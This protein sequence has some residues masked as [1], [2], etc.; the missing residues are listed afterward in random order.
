ML[1][2]SHE[3][4]ISCTDWLLLDDVLQMDRQCVQMHGFLSTIFI[5]GV[6]TAQGRSFS[7]HVFNGYAHGL[8]VEIERSMPGGTKA[9]LPPFASAALLQAAAISPPQDM[10]APPSPMQ[11]FLHQLEAVK[12]AVA[13]E[14]APWPLAAH[15]AARL[16]AQMPRQADRAAFIE[17]LG[18][19][20]IVACQYVDDTTAPCA[21]PGAVAAVVRRDADSA[22]T[23]FAMKTKSAFNYKPN[24]TAVMAILGSP[25][26]DSEELSCDVVSQY[27]LLGCLM[28]DMLTS[29]PLLKETLVKS[30]ALF[31]EVFHAAETGGFSVPVLAAQVPARV[32]PAILFVA[33]LLIMAPRM[34]G[35]LNRLQASW[36]RDILGCRHA[37]EIRWMLLVAQCGWEMRLSS[38][39]W[40]SA[41]MAL[42]RLQTLPLMHPGARMLNLAGASTVPCWATIVWQAM[43][44]PE[45]PAPIPAITECPEFTAE[46]MEAVHT[47]RDLRRSVL[48]RYRDGV[49]KPV[50]AALDKKQLIVA[51]MGAMVFPGISFS[52]LQPVLEKPSFDLLDLDM[53]PN[54]WRAYRCWAILRMTG[55]WPATCFGQRDLPL[56]LHSCPLCGQRDILPS[57]CLCE[58]Q[59]TLALLAG[60]PLRPPSCEEPAFLSML[61]GSAGVPP[62][63]TRIKYVGACV[64]AMLA[65]RQ[66]AMEPL[67]EWESACWD[68][69]G[70][71]S[72]DSEGSSSI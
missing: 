30:R 25:P 69:G 64:A 67:T 39:V 38:K 52:M 24:K 27:R 1:T 36:A 28:D 14:Q 50:F 31:T 40:V 72:C 70:D 9:W 48:K 29:V 23:R 26:P 43:R 16:L 13:S 18:S 44:S 62:L 21:S 19:H 49:V 12:A 65:P 4:G 3:A 59:G 5:L 61:F 11:G 51:A 8:R 2:A 35:K 34:Q 33:P 54:T 46:E 15:V 45:L 63:E 41:I 42:A 66:G 56:V 7:V 60:L 71:V 20:G 17:A 22:C 32:E 57:H 53:G 6:G 47:S 37:P 58:C 10:V 55:L 68:P